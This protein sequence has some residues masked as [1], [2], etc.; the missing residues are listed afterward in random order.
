VADLFALAGANGWAT[1]QAWA[2][3][4][5]GFVLK[6]RVSRTA[7]EGCCWQYDLSYFVA[8]GVARR[9]SFGLCIT[10]D[11]RTPHDTPS[12]KAIRTVI[13]QHPVPEVTS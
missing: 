1:Q 7:D 3:R 6:L 12:I 2:P 11:R 5:D 9:T 4:D 8:P 10:P 13:E